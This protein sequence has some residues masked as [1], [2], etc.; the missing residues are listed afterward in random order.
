MVEI[1]CLKENLKG[2]LQELY[3][4]FQIEDLS[5]EVKKVKDGLARYRQACG[6]TLLKSLY[7]DIVED[8]I[9]LP[10]RVS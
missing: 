9:T 1:D 2:S 4:K 5:K 3:L 7:Y 10:F 8:D 6:S